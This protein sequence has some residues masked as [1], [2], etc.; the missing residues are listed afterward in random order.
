MLSK[1]SS[2]KLSTFSYSFLPC[3]VLFISPYTDDSIACESILLDENKILDNKIK[4]LEYANSILDKTSIEMATTPDSESDMQEDKKRKLREEEQEE[5]EGNNRE[6]R[7]ALATALEEHKK[8]VISRFLADGADFRSADDDDDDDNDDD[9]DDDDYDEDEENSDD[10]GMVLSKLAYSIPDGVKYSDPHLYSLSPPSSH[11]HPSDD[12]RDIIYSAIAAQWEKEAA[13]PKE[14]EEEFNPYTFIR[15]LPSRSLASPLPSSILLPP[16]LPAE[17]KLFTLV[18]DL[19]ETL[20]HC[21]TDSLAQPDL[22][23][24]VLFNS[25]EYTVCYIPT[26]L[27]HSY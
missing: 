15:N 22:V 10:G 6:E 27:V 14:K 17:S 4:L 1:L 24:P 2:L 20:V 16:L 18:L 8:R 9:D 5:D 13:A 26:S 12:T 3:L 25:V 19:D 7:D 21:S 11:S 23:F